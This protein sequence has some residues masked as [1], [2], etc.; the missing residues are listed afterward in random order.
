[1]EAKIISSRTLRALQKTW[2]KKRKLVVF[3]NG[4]FDILHAGHVQ[5]LERAKALGDVLILGLNCDE[6]A[7][8]LNKGPGRPFNSFDDRARVLAALSAVDYVVGFKETTPE[9]LIHLLL[10]DILVKGA[11]YKKQQMA[12]AAFAKRIARI[13]LKKGYSTTALVRKIQRLS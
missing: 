3:T 2:R 10:P 13:P 5:V 11:D 8:A 12:G 6:S 1:M 9:N 7:R 4:V